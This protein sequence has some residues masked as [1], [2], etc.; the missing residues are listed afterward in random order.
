MYLALFVDGGLL[1]YKLMHVLRSILT[2]LNQKYLIS[3]G[4]ISYFDGLQISRDRQQKNIVI[5]ATA[6]T[7]VGCENC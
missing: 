2:E 6:V 1:A 4:N 5:E 7:E 3:T